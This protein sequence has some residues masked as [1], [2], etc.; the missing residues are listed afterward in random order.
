M[1]KG[2]VFGKF[3][4]LHA[5]H[6][7]LID[8]AKQQCDFLYV[9]L[10]YSNKEPIDGLIRKQWLSKA[11][12]NRENTML[13]SFLYNEDEL[14]NTSEYSPFVS[15]IWAKALKKLVP[16]AD[17]LFTS[18]E[19]GEHVAQKMGINHVLFDKERVIKKVS[20]TDIRNNPFNYWSLIS[21]EAKPS[22][23][24]KVVILGSDTNECSFDDLIKIADE[25]AKKISTQ[26][27]K[28]NKILFIDTDINITKS[29]ASFLFN[30]K[31]QVPLWVEEVNSS[32][33]YL[34]LEDDCPFVQDGTRINEEQRRFLSLSHKK[35]L[36][37]NGTQYISI[38]GNWEQRFQTARNII[39]NKIKGGEFFHPLLK[40]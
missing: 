32:H 11:L 3:M 19:Y 21:E 14:P 40:V 15:T 38:N 12:E 30:K 8:F 9:I 20:G 28:A 23:A 6:L 39:D 31:L 5:G 37:E 35:T 24:M 25:H 7:S 29:Y 17:I 1:K 36:N 33:L 34:F 26:I 10:C 18:E 13:I 2:L 27:L 22:F 16:D 4:P